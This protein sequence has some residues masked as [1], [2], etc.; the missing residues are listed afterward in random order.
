MW[1]FDLDTVDSLPQLGR[2]FSVKRWALSRFRRSDY[3][4]N[5]ATALA[6]SVRE[7][8]RALTGTEV[9]GKVCGLLNVSSLGL[10]FSPVNFYFGFDA[11]GNSTHMLAEVSNI[12]WNER[13]FYAHLLHNKNADYSN[14]KEF[15]V[16][17]F[18]P[19]RDQEYRWSI[20]PP[21]D[22]ISIRLGVHDERGHVFE[23]SLALEKQPFSSASA[24][25]QM[26]RKP[27]MI[28][29]IVAGIYWQAL[30]LFIKGVPFIPYEKEEA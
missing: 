10:Y 14:D 30:K 15:K 12:P 21:G 1:W 13:H 11:E 22:T 9:T 16:S 8:M 23:A 25:R 6:E 27:V 28:A 24:R 18:N 29:F 17:P 5:P 4:G 20:S 3:L 26:I 19:H 7:K 2:W